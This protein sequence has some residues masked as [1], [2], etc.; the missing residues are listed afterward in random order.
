MIAV[1]I[2]TLNEEKSI[3]EV[4][5]S[6]P[7]RCRGHEVSKYVVDGGSQDD[8]V[9]VA[10]SSDASV[11]HQSLTGGKGDGL[12]EAIESIDAEIYVTIDGDNT[13]EGGELEKLIEPIEK[14]QAKH[15]IGKRSHRER[16]SITKLNLLGNKLINFMA[17]LATGKKISDMLSGYRAFT[18]DS[19]K[20][21]DF[22]DPGFG[23]E[24]EM[25]VSA[26][27]NNVPIKEVDIKYRRRTGESKL[28]PFRD[29]YRI[30]KT[31]IWIIRDAK[32]LRFFSAIST[33][34][35]IIATYPG[36]LTLMQK[37][38]KGR[39]VNIGPPLFASFLVII[40][41]Q[42]MV[43]GLLADHI[44]NVENRLRSRTA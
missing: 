37:A 10:R 14:G 26:L 5:N 18:E 32:P 21:T 19:L 27:E 7:E 23:I 13:Y 8:T 3:R 22:T 29:G 15:V 6:I 35:L 9:D 44:K 16:G 24:T 30:F 36:Y 38:E 20:Y 33:I 25:T 41:L 28:N 42:I 43:M 17:R 34:L 39:I 11:I 12:R 31:L 4:L 2:P 1:I 40:A